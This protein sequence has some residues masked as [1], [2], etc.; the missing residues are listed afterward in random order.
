MTRI[1]TFSLNIGWRA[2]LKDFGLLPEH[3]LR[4]A[5][6]P[7][8]L[9]ARVGGAL[10]TE[11]YFRFWR[12][13]EAEAGDPLFPLRM[14]ELLSAESFDPPVFAALCS[15]NL[16][17]AVQR[18]ARYKQLLAPMRL[19]VNMDPNGNLTILPQWL[20]AS[21][22]VPRSLQMAELAF[23]VRLARLATRESVKA[24]SVTL[25]LP[26]TAFEIHRL[27]TFFGTI[28][29]SSNA[30]SITFSSADVLRPFLTHNEGMWL[31]FE[32][33][34][35]RRLGTLD[36]TASMAERVGAL[37]LEL[38]PGNA[39][40]IESVADRL[41]I[42][43]RTLQRR[44][45]DEGANFRTLVHDTRERLARHYLANT[46]MSSAEIAFLLGFEDPNSFFRA[47]QEWTGETP[48]RTR[49]ALRLN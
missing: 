42:S 18:L 15:T 46:E 13:L 45:L 47:F 20:H 19:E 22:H 1:Q 23:F 25:P 30:P 39:A 34:L 26:D 48:E 37:L 27:K 40:N 3:V 32:P 10:S 16:M 2:I 49:H 43:K 14:V 44:L 31:V 7:E 41:S 36:A 5:G 12:S 11:E 4:R 21:D 38:L 28:P 33:E 24:V 35:R 17:Q 6:L 29:Q 9:L 8:D